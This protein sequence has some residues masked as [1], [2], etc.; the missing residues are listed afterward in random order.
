MAQ[1]FRRGG[2]ACARF[3]AAA[4]EVRHDIEL[5]AARFG[6][7]LEHVAHRRSTLRLPGSAPDEQDG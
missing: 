3:L 5:P 6:A 7:S 2:G 4:N 1:L